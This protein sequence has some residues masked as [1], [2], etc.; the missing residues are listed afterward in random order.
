MN[1]FTRLSA[2]APPPIAPSPATPQPTILHRYTYISPAQVARRI[3]A[4]R[5]VCS[6]ENFLH[7]CVEYNEIRSLCAAFADVLGDTAIADP[8][9][10]HAMFGS[11]DDY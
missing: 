8:D 3:D 7:C 1:L 6:S 2:P 4:M 5:H 10:F 11:D 9:A